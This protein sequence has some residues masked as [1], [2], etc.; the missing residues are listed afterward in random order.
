MTVAEPQTHG[1]CEIVQGAHVATRPTTLTPTPLLLIQRP[2]LR[3]RVQVL[4]RDHHHHQCCGEN[5]QSWII[6]LSSCVQPPYYQFV[7]IRRRRWGDSHGRSCCCYLQIIWDRS[8]DSTTTITYDNCS[9]IIKIVV[10]P[11]PE[12]GG[13]IT[14]AITTT[15][16]LWRAATVKIIYGDFCQ[17]TL[18]N[19][20]GDK[21][22]DLGCFSDCDT[23]F[24]RGKRWVCFTIPSTYLLFIPQCKK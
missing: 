19:H 7:S 16:T 8:H 22:A 5:Q 23:M 4:G 17:F 18:S 11:H 13:R 6:R 14:T 10:K 21:I 3:D 24:W 1:C 15:A 2:A 20:H 12:I 9:V